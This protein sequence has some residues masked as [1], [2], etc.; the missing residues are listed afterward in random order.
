M[1]MSGYTDDDVMRRGLLESGVPFL[2]KPLSPEAL[3]R[4]MRK[5]LDDAG[6]WKGGRM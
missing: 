5:V 3:A 2:E 1:F 6:R 4:R